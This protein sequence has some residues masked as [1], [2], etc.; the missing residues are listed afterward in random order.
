MIEIPAWGGDY[1][2]IAEETDGFLTHM[3]TDA[4]VKGDAANIVFAVG[5]PA[6]F[7]VHIVDKQTAVVKT[8]LSQTFNG[9]TTARGDNLASGNEAVIRSGVFVDDRLIRLARFRIIYQ[10][11]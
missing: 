9:S 5:T 7:E 1:N 2:Q 6:P 8:N 4:K 11:S 3:V 10:R